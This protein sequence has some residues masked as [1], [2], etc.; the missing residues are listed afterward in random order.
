MGTAISHRL[1]MQIDCAKI[2]D[3]DTFHR[4]FVQLFGF[5]NFYGRNMNA[6]IDCM[7]SLDCP[8]DGMSAVHIKPGETMTLQLLNAADFKKRC[9]GLLEAIVE[10]SAFVNWRLLQDGYHAPLLA[11]AYHV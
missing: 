6:W 3:V 8:S 9:P 2:V 5:P 10:C 11:L 4:E 1:S 7:S